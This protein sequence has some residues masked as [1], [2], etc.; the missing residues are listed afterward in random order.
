[1]RTSHTPFVLCNNPFEP[2]FSE[3]KFQPIKNK[4]YPWR[5][6]I[7]R[8]QVAIGCLNRETRI[9]IFERDVGILGMHFKEHSSIH[10]LCIGK[11]VCD[12]FFKHQF[13]S[14]Q[15]IKRKQE[16]DVLILTE[17]VKRLSQNHQVKICSKAF[18][19]QKLCKNNA[20]QQKT[21]N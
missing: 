9:H 3:K 21:L 19:T 2:I 15:L 6:C 17:L 12:V 7:L 18:Y 11:M 20:V 1:M 8:Y 14:I 13:N 5:P 4:R 10:D 16:T